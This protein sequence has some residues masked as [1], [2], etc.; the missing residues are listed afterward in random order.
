MSEFIICFISHSD[1]VWRCFLATTTTEKHYKQNECFIIS[2]N[3]V[4]EPGATDPLKLTIRWSQFIQYSADLLFFG[5]PK[6]SVSC[7]KEV[8]RIPIQFATSFMFCCTKQIDL[9]YALHKAYLSRLVQIASD[10]MTSMKNEEHYSE[11]K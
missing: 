7:L 9:A 3:N 1:R 4:T 11:I 8:R 2:F 10:K 6:Y 5:P